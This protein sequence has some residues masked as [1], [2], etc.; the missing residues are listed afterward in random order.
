MIGQLRNWRTASAVSALVTLVMAADASAQSQIPSDRDRDS[1]LHIIGGRGTPDCETI[2]TFEDFLAGEIADQ[3][4]ADDGTGPVIVSGFNPNLGPENAAL[5]FDSA[6]PTGMDEDLGSPHM[7]FG[8]P[9]IGGGGAMGSPNA[10]TRPLGKILVIAE[11]LD[12]ADND[13]IIDEPDDADLMGSRFSFDFSLL[14]PVDVHQMTLIDVEAVE[15]QA[16]ATFFDSNG[17]EII[18]YEMEQ[19]G[20]NGVTLNNFP[21]AV[22]VSFMEVVLNGSGGIDEICFTPGVDC[23]N[24]G[25]AD[26]TDIANGTSEDCNGNGIPDECE[27]DCDADGIPDDC[28]PDCDNDGLPDDCEMG[29]CDSDGIPD[30]CEPDSDGDGVPDDCEDDC[31]GNGVPDEDD[32]ANGTSQDCNNNGIPDECEPDCD[33]D[34]IPDD[35]EPDCDNDGV[36][37]DCEPDCDNDGTPDDCEMDCDNDGLPDDCEDDCDNDGLPDDCEMDCDNDG[38]PDDCED[39][40]DNDGLPDDCEPDC[41]NDGV[42]DDC[43][44]DCD[45]DGT[46]DDCE[47]DSDGDGIPDDCD[48]LCERNPRCPASVLIFPIHRS[49]N[50][51]TILCVTNTN[52]N[53]ETPVSFG[54]GTNVHYEYVNTVP[55]PENPFKPLG[56]FVMDRVEYLTPADTFCVATTCHNAV[57]NT[58]GYVVVTA[59]DPNLFDTPWAHD[60]L[61][62]SEALITPSGAMYVLNASGFRAVVDEGMPTDLD[63]DGHVD[64]DCQE[65]ES[66]PDELMQDTFDAMGGHQL[67][68]LNLTGGVSA[69]NRVQFRIWNDNEFPLSST[70]EFKC[71]FDEPLQTISPVFR[72]NYLA[73]NTPNDPT[74]LDLDCDGVGD[75]ETGWFFMDSILVTT[76]GGQVISADGAIYGAI[77][78]GGASPQTIGRELWESAQTQENGEF[79]EGGN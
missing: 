13:G 19:T 47:P 35:C 75:T 45:S 60:Y 79:L 56:C 3:V 10:N 41:D 72:N 39:D 54:G 65:Y 74:E 53:P 16:T 57:P 22:G 26:A 12:D 24:N 40:C 55:N 48:V 29:D 76:E 14:G 61:V 66:L 52:L 43:E 50:F 9:G 15:P 30:D 70:L 5:I 73:L 71:W 31:N 49:N 68:L 34:N 77:T 32:I 64:F 20:D 21:G 69:C 27:P 1:V 51:L 42:P 78:S 62:G 67:T 28:E 25:V 18:S 17:V 23:N 46:P 44:P 36:P 8:G 37:D 33:N 7:D 59:E 4:F 2:I 58:Q 6:N 11:N 63:M 38:L